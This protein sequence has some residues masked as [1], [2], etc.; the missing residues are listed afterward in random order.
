[1]ARSPGERLSEKKK[2]FV[3]QRNPI[4]IQ[5]TNDPNYLYYS[6]NLKKIYKFPTELGYEGINSSNDYIDISIKEKQDNIQEFKSDPNYSYD[7]ILPL[8]FHLKREKKEKFDND[9]KKSSMLNDKFINP[10]RD[11]EFIRYNRNNNFMLKPLKWKCQRQWE[12]THGPN[13]IDKDYIY[14]A[15]INSN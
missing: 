9:R 5:H 11:A 10:E 7:D 13:F 3:K 12:E 15:T 14:P 6:Q 4:T 2:L 1:M 8:E